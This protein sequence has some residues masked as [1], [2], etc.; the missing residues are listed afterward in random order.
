MESN[1]P[2]DITLEE[3]AKNPDGKTYNG[4]KALHFLTD[5]LGF[6][7][8]AEDIKEII[9]ELKKAKE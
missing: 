1:I 6:K 7:I 3:Y 9:E 8:S 4:V 2:E 5:S